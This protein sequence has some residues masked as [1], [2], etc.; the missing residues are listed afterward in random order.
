M[1][2]P[3]SDRLFTAMPGSPLTHQAAFYRCNTG[4]P[5]TSCG[6]P[7]IL[8]YETISG[9]SSAVFVQP[10]S[11]RKS[12]SP[13]ARELRGALCAPSIAQLCDVCAPLRSAQKQTSTGRHA[14]PEAHSSHT[15]LICSLNVSQSFSSFSFSSSK[16]A[17]NVSTEQTV[18]EIRQI[19]PST[20]SASISAA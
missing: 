14:P 13:I 10:E 5:Q 19:A 15:S 17:R 8:M 6:R 12:R 11:H 4:R 2:A 1:A 9:A 16:S 3:S 20:D 18:S 7:A